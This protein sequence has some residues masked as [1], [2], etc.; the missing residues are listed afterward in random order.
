MLQFP[1]GLTLGKV[2]GT[3]LAQNDDMPNLAKGLGEI[4]KDLS[5]KDKL[6][7]S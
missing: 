7:S 4:K 3:R 2:V 6:P 1:L 5:A